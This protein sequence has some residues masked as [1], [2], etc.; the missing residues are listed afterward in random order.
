[1][2][3]A[4]LKLIRRQRFFFS[5]LIQHNRIYKNVFHLATIGACVHNNSSTKA[6]RNACRKFHAC[7]AFLCRSIRNLRKQCTCL[8]SDL[9]L[10][11]PDL[12]GML[13]HLDHDA[14]YTFVGNKK[15][16]SVSDQCIWNILTAAQLNNCSNTVSVRCDQHIG[17]SSHTKC[18][19][20]AHRLLHM[21]AG[22]VCY[23]FQLCQK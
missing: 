1:M 19:M 17:R 22:T 13:S 18:C 21:N 2:P 12:S 11:H 10:C 20:S 4:K 14:T 15:V 7:K 9:I 6:S 16:A 23:T 3:V 5:I 8:C